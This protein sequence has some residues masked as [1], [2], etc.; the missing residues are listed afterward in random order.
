MMPTATR[1]RNSGRPNANTISRRGP[2]PS[3]S[4][5][6]SPSDCTISIAS[7]TIAAR[8]STAAMPP[9]RCARA[10]RQS[11]AACMSAAGSHRAHA[12][13]TATATNAIGTP[14]SATRPQDAS[15]IDAA[16]ISTG[17]S[18][19]RPWPAEIP[20]ANV[21]AAVS[22]LP[23]DAAAERPQKRRQQRER[24]GGRSAKAGDQAEQRRD[25]RRI[26]ETATGRLPRSADRTPPNFR[27]ALR[28][29]RRRRSPG[30]AQASPGRNRRRTSC[31][32]TRSRTRRRDRM[33]SP[34]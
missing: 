7:G 15:R 9:R 17:D 27:R 32:R 5:G 31:R 22:L 24:G 29:S 1:N 13:P 34:R 3:G 26:R 23:R 10:L 28:R 6:I 18:N 21:V 14:N 4:L 16:A 30:R 19:R 8:T 11:A 25:R 2:P 20:S 12:A 33:P